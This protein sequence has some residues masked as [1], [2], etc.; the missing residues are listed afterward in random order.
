MTLDIQRY[1]ESLSTRHARLYIEQVQEMTVAMALGQRPRLAAARDRLIAVIT[2]AMGVAEVLGA[3]AALRKTAAFI[4][5]DP[6]EHFQ[7]HARHRE[8]LLFAETPSNTLLPRVTLMEAVEDMVRRTPVA[9]RNAAERSAQAISK[10][11]SE[12]RV[13]AFAKTAELA[14][15][16][17]VQD[18]VSWSIAEGIP[19]ASSVINGRFVPGAGRLITLGAA[20]IAKETAPW[21]E[22]YSRTAFRT[23]L[24]TAVTAGRFRQLQDPDIAEIIP[25][26]RFDSVGDMDTRH[27]HDAADGLIFLASN[28]VWNKIAPPLG[29]NCRC[30]VVHMSRPMLRRLGRLSPNGKVLE[31]SLPPTAKPDKGFNHG[32][33]PDLFMVGLT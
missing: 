12:G 4:T 7:L 17:R 24:N 20:K 14:V 16:K 28:P 22:S 32:G 15:T 26:L 2:E 3:T 27:N 1:I 18:L 29:Y 11:Y 31:S 23:N 5:E 9:I 30:Q 13:V 21:V 6:P 25:A 19:E 33:R 10:L 8:I